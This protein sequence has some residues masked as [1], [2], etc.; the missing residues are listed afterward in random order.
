[1]SKSDRSGDARH[2]ALAQA[3]REQRAKQVRV[4]VLTWGAIA[5]VV[6]GLAVATAFIIANAS[7]EREQIAEA[8]A[9]P[10]D[11]VEEQPDQS[12]S[13]VPALPE[14]TPNLATGVLLP[15]SGGD[16]DP[17]WLN[18]GVYDSPVPTANAVHSLEHGAVWVTYAPGLGEADVAA[19]RTSVE[20]YAYSILSPFEDLAAPVVLTAWGVQLEVDSAT[21][22]RVDVFLA[23]YVQG[24]QTPEPGAACS[25]GVG[26]PL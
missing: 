25:S 13:H 15:P 8:A 2:E 17:A 5:L 20:G 4:R 26:E 21:D 1:M 9:A 16:H 22:E 3:Q 18:C 19:L 7:A 6:G 10:I 11:G 24:E 14:P 23:K 12:A